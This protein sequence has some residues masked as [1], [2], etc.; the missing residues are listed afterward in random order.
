LPR[1][2]T[3]GRVDP[4]RRSP[5]RPAASQPLGWKRRAAPNASSRASAANSS[6]AA[7][8]L[9][10]HAEHYNSHRPH[11][12]LGPSDHSPR[13]TTSDA[14]TVRRHDRLGEPF[15]EYYQVAAHVERLWHPQW[16][17]RRAAERPASSVSTESSTARGRRRTSL[18]RRRQIL[19]ARARSS[20]ATHVP[21]T[22]TDF[23]RRSC[24]YDGSPRTSSG[25]PATSQPWNRRPRSHTDT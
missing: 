4:E 14:K 8:V 13:A 20:P 2:S 6:N 5:G 1:R 24:P 23:P 11:R 9:T 25:S 17:A 3:C 16:S 12:A 7:T 22:V 18:S 19:A 15:H 10:E 21:G